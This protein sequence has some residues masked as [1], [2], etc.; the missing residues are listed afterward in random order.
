[1]TVF[2]DDLAAMFDGFPTVTVSFGAVTAEAYR[3]S[4]SAETLPGMAGGVVAENTALTFPTSRFPGIAIGSALTVD[5]EAFTVRDK[6]L[7]PG[8]VDGAVTQVLLKKADS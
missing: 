4:W 3:D 6:R 2:D 8:M 7:P 1:M 5:G